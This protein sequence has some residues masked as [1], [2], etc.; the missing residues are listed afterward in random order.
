MKL[1]KKSFFILMV[2]LSAAM[3]ADEPDDSILAEEEKED[4]AV[5]NNYPQHELNVIM[6]AYRLNLNPALASYNS[7]AQILNSLYEGLF[8]Y[9]SKTLDPIPAIAESFK[10]SKNKKRWTFTIRKNCAF[11]DGTPITAQT[12][13]DSWISLLSTPDAPYASLLDCIVNAA[14]FR[15]GKAK[16]EAVGINAKDDQ[17][18]IVNLNSPTAH[19]NRILCHHAF[20]VTK[21]DL[22]A[23]SGAYAIDR[24]EKNSLHL[25]KNMHYWDEKHVQIPSI[26]I[27]L[28][29]DETE[30]TWLF[31]TGR[32]DW[33][34]SIVDSNKLLNKN[35]IRLSAI[36]GTTYLF[37]NCKNSPWDKADFRNALLTAVPWKELRSSHLIPATTL[38]YPISGY[39]SPEGLTETSEEDALEMMKE[40][41]K[42]AGIKEDEILSVTYA[43]SSGSEVHKKQAEILKKAWEKLGVELKVQT[44]TEDRYIES[45]SG[46]NA[47]IFSYSW[48]G[49]YADPSAFLELFREG[50][51][52]NETAW[53][54]S[55]F[56]K[57]LTESDGMT[58]QSERYKLLSKAEEILLNDGVV[59]PVGHSLSLHAI[60][61][62]SIGGWYTNALDIHPFRTMFFRANTA[63]RIKNIA[64]K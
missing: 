41:R 37:F 64:L 42:K 62:N 53:K 6:S 19:F 57:T 25:I 40:A 17:T 32:T 60:D 1:L 21:K 22:S 48:I 29:N 4:T 14:D 34:M 51:T 59:M 61:L 33:I 38:V 55:E 13:R 10:I 28:S 63:P 7:E 49:D 16:A 18:L 56:T 50:S 8:N 15:N 35:T 20:S 30:N 39:T 11:S 43:V 23:Y 44:T 5:Q 26:Q 27:S 47:D 3:F 52:L 36:F 24:N 31:N 45:I 58:N 12:V 54:N 46:W 2:F 9:D